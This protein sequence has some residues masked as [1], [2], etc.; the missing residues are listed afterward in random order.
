MVLV[1]VAVSLILEMLHLG[2]GS[3]ARFNLFVIQLKT[4]RKSSGEKSI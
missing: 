3:L 1:V 2:N 4:L